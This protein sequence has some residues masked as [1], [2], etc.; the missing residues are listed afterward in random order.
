MIYNDIMIY[1][2]IYRCI[3]ECLDSFRKEYKGVVDLFVRGL[4]M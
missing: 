2:Y 3:D 1:I 4:E